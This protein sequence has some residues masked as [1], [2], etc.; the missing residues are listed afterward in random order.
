M[1][2][3]IEGLLFDGRIGFKQSIINSEIY[4]VIQQR[5]T[6]PKDALHIMWI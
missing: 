3:G 1:E 6:S 4:Q 2:K 5:L